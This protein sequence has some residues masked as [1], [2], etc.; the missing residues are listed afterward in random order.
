MRVHRS[1]H[2]FMHTRTHSF[3]PSL[4]LSPA[5]V[6]HPPPPNPHTPFPLFLPP[7]L[8]FKLV[9]GRSN[10]SLKR[11]ERTLLG[12][13]SAVGGILK[14]K[15]D[16]GD[17]A[18]FSIQVAHVRAERDILVEA[19][20]TWVV[21]MFYSFQDAQYLYLIMEFLPGGKWLTVNSTSAS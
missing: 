18:V 2:A 6:S 9:Y 19:D 11:A 8:L 21:K 17:T 4:F 13:H 10:H 16:S 5:L 20:H 1:T 7:Y 3:P 15:E 14:G 12:L